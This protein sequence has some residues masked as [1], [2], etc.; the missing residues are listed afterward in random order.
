MGYRF[1]AAQVIEDVVAWIRGWFTE[2]GPG[3]N[4]VIGLSGG[5]DSTVAAALC[6]HA[7]GAERVIGVVMP[8][9]AQPDIE[10]SY[11][12]AAHL[13]IR[14]YNIPITLAAGDTVAQLTAAGISPS[15]QAMVNLPARLRMA[16]LY[17]V[18]QSMNGRV[19]NTC[20]LSEDWV[21]YSTR[22]G[23]SVGD[24][25]PLARLT[26]TEIVVVGYMLGLPG[27]LVSK[28]P[29]D[30]LSGKTDEENFGF[31]Y[32]EL[33]RY[34]RT[35]VYTSDSIRLR[36]DRKHQ[37]NIFKLSMPPVFDPDLP[38]VRLPAEK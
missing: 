23:D 30:G 31:T 19:V 8:N 28:T 27:Y 9:I 6:V 17:A 16:T 15:E 36:I 11:A 13:G 25:C 4:A 5:K 18:S 12:A 32:D 33:D 38:V 34:I 29:S 2:N 24:L 21:G 3:C 22:W 14:L 7:L 10:D 1:N 35:G 20:N 37:Q 26:A